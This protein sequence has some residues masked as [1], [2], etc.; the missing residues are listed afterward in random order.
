MF[1]MYK[2]AMLCGIWHPWVQKGEISCSRCLSRQVAVPGLEPGR[3]VNAKPGSRSL[4]PS[5]LQ[6][7]RAGSRPPTGPAEGGREPCTDVG[8]NHRAA[9]SLP[10]S[11]SCSAWAY[12][13]EQV[14]KP[15]LG[16]LH[17]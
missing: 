12:F 13:L 7:N 9:L 17:A 10:F 3:Q 6:A 5:R 1:C 14:A 15:P 8:V 16:H 11:S 4:L 2:Y